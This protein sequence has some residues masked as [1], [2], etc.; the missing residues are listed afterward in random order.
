MK[1]DVS[2]IA[3]ALQ[4]ATSVVRR[5]NL[6]GAGLGLPDFLE[7]GIVWDGKRSM[8]CSSARWSLVLDKRVPNPINSV[9][10]RK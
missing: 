4:R 8:G 2:V 5:R 7:N 6:A 1:L 9:N 10:L 3:F